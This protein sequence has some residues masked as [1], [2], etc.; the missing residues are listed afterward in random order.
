MKAIHQILAI[1]ITEFRF[2]LRRGWPIV[3]TI[4]VLLVMGG[5]ILVFTFINLS[6]LPRKYA[7][8]ISGDSLITIWP[9]FPVIA[10]GVLTM[11]CSPAISMDRQMGVFELIRS[12]PLTGFRYI[13]GKII[14]TIVSVLFA[15]SIML[16]L[17]LGIHFV[18]LG[19]INAPLYLEVILFSGLPILIWATALGVV[20]G[21]W[22]NKRLSAVIIGLLAGMMGLL[23]WGWFSPPPEKTIAI[24]G[25]T[26]A[27]INR[28]VAHSAITEWIWARYGWN[29]P[30][31]PPVPGATVWLTFGCAFLML[32]VAGMFAR[33]WLYWKENF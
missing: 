4:A 2:G 6:D 9:A 19:P 1:S 3:G 21:T 5:S 28:Y 30:W 16:V 27:W 32:V 12:M 14:G 8:E 26:S 13:L 23:P 11:A 15:G 25:L 18:F 29:D 20:V 31:W 17:F 22:A 10:L 24:M 7:T 33:I